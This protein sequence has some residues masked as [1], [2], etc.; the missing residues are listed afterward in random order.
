MSRTGSEM[1]SARAMLAAGIRASAA[2][3]ACRQA[4]SCAVIAALWYSTTTSASL[5]PDSPADRLPSALPWLPGGVRELPAARRL[6]TP[7]SARL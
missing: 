1:L 2:V 7:P 6:N 3:T 4:G 5:R